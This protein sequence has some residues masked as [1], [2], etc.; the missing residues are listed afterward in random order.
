[1][2]IAFNKSWSVVG[3]NSKGNVHICMFPCQRRH[4]G[5]CHVGRGPV[6]TNLLPG[7]WLGF[8]LWSQLDQFCRREIQVSP[9]FALSWLLNSWSHGES[10]EG[11][12]EGG[13]WTSTGSS[14]YSSDYWEP[15]PQ[16]HHLG[17]IHILL[18]VHPNIYTIFKP[19]CHSCFPVGFSKLFTMWLNHD[20][21]PMN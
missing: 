5:P 20:Q 4:R 7:G 3:K 9:P 11:V 6:I 8:E 16:G 10:M 15:L 18:G 12:E 21:S 14:S 1:M 2:N 17:S 13:W 19:P